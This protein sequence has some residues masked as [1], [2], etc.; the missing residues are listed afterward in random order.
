[1]KSSRTGQDRAGKDK[2]GKGRVCKSGGEER[3]RRAKK[4]EKNK[5]E[6]RWCVSGRQN[7][8]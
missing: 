7:L 8:K 5:N 1:M 3:W 2:A 4:S 6:V